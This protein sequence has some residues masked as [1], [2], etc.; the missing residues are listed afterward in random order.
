M[1][2][3]VVVQKVVSENISDSSLQILFTPS[4]HGHLIIAS[5]D[6]ELMGLWEIQ[7]STYQDSVL[8]IKNIVSSYH[9][10]IHQVKY[11][12]KND[13]CMP[14]PDG[15]FDLTLK[16]L[17]HKIFLHNDFPLTEHKIFS[18]ARMHFIFKDHPSSFIDSTKIVHHFHFTELITRHAYFIKDPDMLLFHVENSFL[19]YV[20]KQNH[21]IVIATQEKI[22]QWSDVIYFLH[23]AL[24]KLQLDKN[25][26]TFYLSA[27]SQIKNSL[28]NDSKDL[29]PFLN[30]PPLI[31]PIDVSLLNNE[32]K[33]DIALILTGMLCES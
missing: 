26:M 15:L 2:D 27:P 30:D 19:F 33:N 31:L 22:S 25:D 13:L 28:I 24:E 10:K 17:F 1:P 9:C 14:V 21:E 20:I 3:P 12:L 4:Q 32:Q 23:F 8:F 6:K 18:K 7:D 29:L 5:N 16:N 11:F